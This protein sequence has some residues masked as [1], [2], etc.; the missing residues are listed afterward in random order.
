MSHV[1]RLIDELQNPAAYS[2]EAGDIVLHQTHISLVFLAGD[3]AYKLKKPV[4]FGFVDYSTLDA[5]REFCEREVSL[6]RRLAS[7]VYLGV[8]PVVER[9]GSL[10]MGGE[11]DVASG[12]AVEWAVKMRRLNDADTLLKRL[13]D[14]RLPG[15][16]MERL[17]IH[18]AE[19]H[20]AAE[21]GSR[22]AEYGSFGQVADNTLGNLEE[23]R[24]HVGDVVT[25][26]VHGRVES[27]TREALSNLE[28]IIDE[29]ADAGAPC[30]THGDL[31]LEH[32]YVADDGAITIVDC[33]EFNDAFRYADPVSDIAFL[34]MDL[35]VRGYDRETATV[36]DA[37]FE[38]TGD[39][40]VRQ[41]LDFYIAYRS[42]VRA[43]VHGFKAL[44]GEVSE[45]ERES[46]R[47]RSGM[48][49][50]FA[51]TV[52]APPRERPRLVMAGGLPG[53]G[54]STVAADLE[55]RGWL[56]AVIRSDVVR[57]ELAGLGPGESAADAYGEGIYSPEWTRKVYD[58]C[59]ERAAALLREGKRV[60]ID[61][62]FHEDA[63]RAEC[64][65]LARELG[66]QPVFIECRL[67]ADEAARRMGGRRGDASDADAAV[68]E[69]MREAWEAPSADVARVHLQLDTTGSPGEVAERAERLLSDLK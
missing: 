66:V 50:R 8:V 57:K 34:A 31:R 15:G 61:A 49:W 60:A 4:D 69:R 54:K 40:D 6:N 32:V 46:A 7:D 10:V 9:D 67:P 3:F 29:R 20:D 23:T 13:A 52:L 59:R 36:L 65:R 62:S 5:R 45:A 33:V 19:F 48:H 47:A 16:I 22:I 12:A 42:C 17:G 58:E 35:L 39:R 68:H 21:R 11:D 63:Q 2:H 14:D 43:K 25:P 30:D 53:T 56:D 38:A 37:W 1:D 27:L 44:D 24:P 41:L 18:L 55:E 28:G 51:L 64:V 26:E